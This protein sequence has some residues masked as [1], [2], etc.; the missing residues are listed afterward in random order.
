MPGSIKILH[1]LHAFS[2]GGLENGIVNLINRSPEKLQHELCLLSRGGDFLNRLKRPVVYYELHKQP[3]N[4][5]GIVLRIREI[6]LKSKADIVHTRNWAAFDGVLASC[7]APRVALLHGE[8]GRDITDPEGLNKRRN[9][10]RR[11]F[12]FR[13][14][15]FVVVSENLRR[16]LTEVVRVPKEKLVFIPNGVDTERF[17]PSCGSG[18]RQELGIGRDEFVVG[19]IG[20]LDPVKNH[21]GLLRAV[22]ILSRQGIRVRLVIV[23]DGPEQPRLEEFLRSKSIKPAPILLGYRSDVPEL[24][25][26]FDLFVL[27]SIAEGMSNTLLEAMASALPI[28]CTAVGGNVELVAD[29]ERGR[30]VPAANDEALAGRISEYLKSVELRRA[31]GDESRKFVESRFSLRQMVERY[32]ELY[33]ATVR[34][35]RGL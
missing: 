23:G 1:V 3:G 10:L 35:V 12:R 19:S 2:A 18:L 7:L 34:P 11:L 24:Y 15:K 33:Q 21:L 29:G 9:L 31:H 8:H 16:W 5:L 13:I 22:E 26:L 32:F 25:R 17:Q 14:Q 28:I 4:D 20:R 30:W 6:L 27:N